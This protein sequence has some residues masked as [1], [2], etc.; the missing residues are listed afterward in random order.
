MSLLV[1]D[2][3]VAVAAAG[4]VSDALLGRG[5]AKMWTRAGESVASD[6]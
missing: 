2:V 6:L 3:W 1:S 5:A 4:S